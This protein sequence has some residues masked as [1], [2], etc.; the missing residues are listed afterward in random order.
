[1]GC[2]RAY[3]RRGCTGP[4]VLR[5]YRK[6]PGHY[7]R[8]NIVRRFMVFVGDA[9][10]AVCISAPRVRLARKLHRMQKYHASPLVTA[11]GVSTKV[12]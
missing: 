10:I 3:S 8:G 5:A 11:S 2:R 4:V 1:M 6:R 7:E 12:D 9:T